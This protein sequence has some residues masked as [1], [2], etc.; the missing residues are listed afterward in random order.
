MSLLLRILIFSVSNNLL[1]AKI[2][3]IR[4]CSKNAEYYSLFIVHA[5]AIEFASF[6]TTRMLRW[7]LSTAFN[8]V[9]R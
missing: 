5:K 6:I 3:V 8:G 2:Y 9:Y 1:Y 7:C 4:F